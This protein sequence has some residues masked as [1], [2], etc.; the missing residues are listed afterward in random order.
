MFRG[1]SYTKWFIMYGIIILATMLGVYGQDISYY[2]NNILASF[3]P[4]FYL[5]IITSISVLLFLIPPTL[6]SKFNKTQK[7]EVEIFNLYYGINAV[8]GAV[9]SAFSLLVL[10][11][12]WN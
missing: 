4:L 12:G 3:S 6:I 9:T 7:S 1:R 5:T 10:L 11:I 8:I 2:I